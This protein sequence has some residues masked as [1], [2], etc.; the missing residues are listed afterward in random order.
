MPF[1]SLCANITNKVK[2][3]VLQMANTNFSCTVIQGGVSVK[4][5]YCK[6]NELLICFVFCPFFVSCP[7]IVDTSSYL[8]NYQ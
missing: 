7:G 5:N 1:Y 2:R 4:L 8:H 3:E 6:A